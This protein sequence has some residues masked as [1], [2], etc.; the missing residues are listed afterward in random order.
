MTKDH[1]NAD[2]TINPIQ[3]MGGIPL[4]RDFSSQLSNN[5]EFKAQIK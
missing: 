5:L 4:S 2:H 1:D 3:S